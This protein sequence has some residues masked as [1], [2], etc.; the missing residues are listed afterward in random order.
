MLSQLLIGLLLAAA[1]SLAA[2]LARAL[3]WSGAAAATV[4][5]TV[6]FG[7]GGWQW[8]VLL[9]AFFIL[10]SALTR[11]FRR[12]KRGAE[13]KYA[14]GGERDA[15]QV[16]SNGGLA[17]IFVLLHAAFP[18]AAWPWIGYA[19]ALA[20]VNADTWAT[21]LGVLDPGEPRLI[22][23]LRRRVEKGT[24]G[25]VSVVGTLASLAGAAII[26]GLAAWFLG[27][28]QASVTAI[29]ALAGLVGSLVDSLLGATLQ[30]IYYCPT[31]HKETEKHPLHTCGTKTIHLRGWKWLNNDWV[32]IACSVAGALAALGGAV[33]IGL[34]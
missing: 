13:E 32:N 31:D 24:S 2:R 1:A 33:L 14:K 17:G 16:V 8:A 29:V 18:G 27:R 12:L 21:E 3:S 20:A 34:R 11:A 25:G 23:S 9:L 15:M 28:D 30:A 10:S 4:L 26:G 5:G 7:L 6:V 22:S 19:G